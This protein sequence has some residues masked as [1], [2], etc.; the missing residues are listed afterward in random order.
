MKKH[1]LKGREIFKISAVMGLQ[2]YKEFLADGETKNKLFGK[3]YRTFS[4]PLGAKAFVVESTHAFCSAFDSKVKAEKLY[5]VSLI[6]E[7]DFFQYSGH[8]TI[9]QE[10]D[11]ASTEQ[12]LKSYENTT[13]VPAEL[14]EDVLNALK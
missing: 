5:S 2:K 3:E 10:L 11:M 13:I 9:G 4:H 8:S 14:T 12:L 1:E 6:E 7:D